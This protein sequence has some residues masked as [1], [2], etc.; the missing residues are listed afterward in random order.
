MPGLYA[1]WDFNSGQGD[2]LYD[3]SAIKTTEQL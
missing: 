2:I 1:S 3:H